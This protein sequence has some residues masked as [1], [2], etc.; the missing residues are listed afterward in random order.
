[1]YAAEDGGAV[2]EVF[3]AV[4]LFLAGEGLGGVANVGYVADAATVVP[5]HAFLSPFF[6][7]FFVPVV[8]GA[9]HDEEADEY[10]D[11]G[12]YK[13]AEVVIGVNV[14]EQEEGA[15]GHE[16]EPGA[17]AEAVAEA[18]EEADDDEEGVPVEEPVG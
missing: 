14:L 7:P 6:L 4:A 2:D 8:A 16:D 5:F 3:A 13:A 18:E 15:D 12:P 1:M 9:E 11:G 10:E 17:A